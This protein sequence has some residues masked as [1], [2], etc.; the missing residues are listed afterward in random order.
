MY[1]INNVLNKCQ[2]KYSNTLTPTHTHKN[3]YLENFTEKKELF[4]LN[5]NVFIDNNTFK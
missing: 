4:L 5:V 2:N 1:Q 3:I